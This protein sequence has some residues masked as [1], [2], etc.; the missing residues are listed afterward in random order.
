MSEIPAESLTRIRQP[1]TAPRQRRHSSLWTVRDRLPQQSYWQ[2]TP[3]FQSNRLERAAPTNATGRR[4]AGAGT[5]VSA[6]SARYIEASTVTPSIDG[7]A[8]TGSNASEHLMG[9]PLRYSMSGRD[10]SRSCVWGS[11]RLGRTPE[12]RPRA[13][14]GSSCTQSLNTTV[15]LPF[16]STR[17]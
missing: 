2:Q 5:S 17:D 6:Q 7:A 3:R 15:L 4:V 13:G 12:S 8:G 11:A 1:A 16:I 9:L 14:C 10:C